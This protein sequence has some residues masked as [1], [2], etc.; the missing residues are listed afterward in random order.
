MAVI[1]QKCE[2]LLLLLTVILDSTT[3]LFLSQC[4]KFKTFSNP[5]YLMQNPDVLHLEKAVAYKFIESTGYL[6]YFFSVQ[7]L[8]HASRVSVVTLAY[9]G[10]CWY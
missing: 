10:Y 5:S 9:D 3:V 2:K 6:V 4:M 8:V 1:H 7:I